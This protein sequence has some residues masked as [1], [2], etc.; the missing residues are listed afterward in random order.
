MA[1]TIFT[2]PGKLGDA[3]HQWP[4][5]HHWTAENRQPVTIWLDEG[6]LKPLLPLVQ[7]QPWVDK[8]ELRKGIESYHCGGQPW[9]F[10]IEAA[11]AEGRVIH[12]LGMRTFPQRQLTLECIAGCGLTLAAD[13]KLLAETPAFVLPPP[14]KKNRL[15]LHGMSVYPHSRTTPQFW[16]FI[17]A[18]RGELM[19]TFDEIVFTGSPMDREVSLATYPEWQELDDGG[20]FLKL[21]LFMNDA[22]LVIGCGS[23]VAALAQALRLPCVR[24]HDPI[25]DCPKVIWSGLGDNQLNDGEIELRT[26]WPSFRDQFVKTHQEA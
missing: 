5:V 21:A 26:G 11:E 13:Q 12:H 1:E 4:V 20:D 24:V 6:S 16:K 19:Q 25:G 10:G 15:V 23:S 14:E 9:N 2:L 7:S 22:R 8:V 17:A 3:I 18:I